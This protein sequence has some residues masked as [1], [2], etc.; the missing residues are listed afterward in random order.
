[1]SIHHDSK[2]MRALLS[3]KGADGKP[4][5][6]VIHN[7]MIIADAKDV[8]DDKEIGA[9]RKQPITTVQVQSTDPNAAAAL[10]AKDAEIKTLKDQLAKSMIPPAK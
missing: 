1:M 3:D 8:P 9:S 7:G 5:S 10:A 6:G 2:S 4:K